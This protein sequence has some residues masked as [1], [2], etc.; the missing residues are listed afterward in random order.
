MGVSDWLHQ[1]A[2]EEQLLQKKT[3][4]Q[5]EFIKQASEAWEEAIK[6]A[7]STTGWKEEKNGKKIYR[8]K[9][10]VAAP[11]ALLIEAMRD[12]D[13]VVDWNKTLLQSKLL[14]RINDEFS[15]TY[16]VTSDGGGGMVSSRDF[17]YCAKTGFK[18]DVFVMGG[19]SVD[20]K[21]AP[22]SSKIVRAINGPGCQM[23]APVAGDPNS[24]TFIWLMYCDYKGWMPQS[25]LDIAM[26]IA[27]TQFIECLKK[28]AQKLKDEGKF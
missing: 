17:V 4:S 2:V 16:Q 14:K 21:D 8:C 22:S 9:A 26:P 12:T 1:G 25:V 11:P 15:I 19:R 27:Q 10:T 23:I 5:A 7:E 24:S 13:K 3:M 6:I 28:L 18:G 20:Y